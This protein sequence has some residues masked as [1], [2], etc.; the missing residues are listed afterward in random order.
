[1]SVR[2]ETLTAAHVMALQLQPS[3]LVT[4][5]L[6]E[7]T[8]SEAHAVELATRGPAW[9]AFDGDA[10]LVCAGL[11]ELF[12]PA[13]ALAWAMLSAGLGARLL[14]ITRFAR[15]RIAAAG[16]ARVEAIVRTG[17]EV[18]WARAVGLSPAHIL[19]KWGAAAEDHILMERI[20]A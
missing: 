8:V 19:R 17:A 4:A 15:S 5:G 13:H 18:A 7:P 1:V 11:Y 14:P 3:Q 20:A 12:P 10:L 2:F 6:Y 9:A 16:Y